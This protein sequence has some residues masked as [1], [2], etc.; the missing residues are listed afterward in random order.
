MSMM[1]LEVIRW[2]MFLRGAWEQHPDAKN[3]E[4]VA[5][6]RWEWERERKR[7]RRRAKLTPKGIEYAED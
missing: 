4:A 6:I 2:A 7:K 1:K 5:R 3:A